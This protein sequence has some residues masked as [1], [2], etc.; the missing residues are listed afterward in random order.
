[1]D[2]PGRRVFTAILI[3]LA[4]LGMG[5][6]VI[7]LSGLVLFRSQAQQEQA[8]SPTVQIITAQPSPT[9]AQGETL[10]PTLEVP[11]ESVPPDIAAQM[12]EIEKQVIGLRGLDK[13]YK[14]PRV[15]I[16]P[17]ELRTRMAADLVME[18]TPAEQQ[19]EQILMTA[20]GML[21]P[22]LDLR[23]TYLDLLS[24]GV[25]GFYDPDEKVMYV[26]QGSSF[27]GV[28]RL[29]YAHEFTHAL[30]D[31]HFNLRTK[32]KYSGQ[33][34]VHD[35]QRCSA[36]QALIEGDA[37][38]TQQLWF[39]RYATAQDRQQVSDV[40]Q[41]PS[42]LFDASPAYL[43]EDFLYP[44]SSGL[45]YVVSLWNKGGW[46]AVDAAYTAPP[47]SSEQIMHPDTYPDDLPRPIK[48]PDLTPVLGDGWNLL[49]Q[50]TLGEW[51]TYLT[52]AYSSDP[53]ARLSQDQASLSATGWKGDQFAVYAGPTGSPSTVVVVS[54]WDTRIDSREFMDALRASGLVRWGKPA[55]DSPDQLTW[56][57]SSQSVAIARN[58][59]FT[60][61]VISP[62]SSLTS[63]IANKLQNP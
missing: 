48:L 47:L 29:T 7:A 44:Y 17:E 57:T 15:L 14:I 5:A 51:Y 6:V 34:C 8:A 41:K 42:P 33:A 37:T 25:A 39:T 63:A 4:V 31:Q 30:Q 22:G 1:M 16:T 35:L 53:K 27:T 26:V 49:E 52:L 9:L 28:E 18:Y 32:L 55:V 38:Y 12:D 20:L 45:E 11:T 24:E 10:Q 50:D 23:K 43:Q 36:L 61:W 54:Q 3:I 13:A 58:D 19:A 40:T 59:T 62:Q 60:F 56:E 46:P 21:P 2:V